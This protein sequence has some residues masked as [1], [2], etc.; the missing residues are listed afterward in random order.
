MSRRSRRAPCDSPDQGGSRVT[1]SRTGFVVRLKQQTHHLPDQL[2]RPGRQP[3]GP[4]APVLLRDVHP[5]NRGEPV[6]LGPQQADDLPNSSQTHPV[7]CLPVDPG[8]HRSAVGVDAPVGHQEQLLVEQLPIQPLQG[9]TVSAPVAQ[10]TEH[11]VS[12]LHFAYLQGVFG[13]RI[14]CAPSPC[15]RLSRSPWP[16]VTP[17]TTTSTPSPPAVLGR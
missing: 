5:P 9:Q 7:G 8:R 17:A 6:A 1:G 2:V 11:C 12:A 10:D 15:E 14:T 13:V 3:Q 4:Q 16:G